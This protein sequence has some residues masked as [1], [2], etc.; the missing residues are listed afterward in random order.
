LDVE[1][2]TDGHSQALAAGLKALDESDDFVARGNTFESDLN[3]ARIAGVHRTPV[4]RT[5]PQEITP[6]EALQRYYTYAQQQLATSVGTEPVGSAALSGFGKLY[7]VLAR[8]Q[9]T[10][11]LAAQ[12][13][14][15]TL[16]QAA[17]VVDKNNAAAA[18]ELGVLL[19]QMGNLQDAQ[20]WLQHSVSL[21]P[22][23]ATWHN[24]AVVHERLGQNDLAQQARSHEATVA[25]RSGRRA[26]SALPEIRWVAPRVLDAAPADR[27]QPPPGTRSASLPD[28]SV[29]RLPSMQPPGARP[30]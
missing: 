14:A 27:P 23:A 29:S 2:R 18:N 4:V 11:V 3:V 15:M 13:K 26:T 19:A 8:D 7:T 10:E 20:A 30:F 22:Q 21:A 12:A 1:H 24:L 16:H 9:S 5:D 25:Q 6:R 28:D 17:L